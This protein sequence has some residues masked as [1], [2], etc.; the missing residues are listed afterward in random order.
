M[1]LNRPCRV[2]IRSVIFSLK[3]PKQIVH[4]FGAFF[5]PRSFF[6]KKS[7]VALAVLA[8]S[9]ASFAQSSVTVY[10][11][12][13]AWLGS[14]K[15]TSASGAETTTTT[16][17]SGGVSHDRWGFK[18]SED[19]GGGLKANFNLEQGFA[20]DTG[21]HDSG[22]TGF[23][24]YAWVGLSGGFGEIKFGKTATAY[25][26]IQ[27]AADAVFDSALSP[28]ANIFV[29]AND[30]T[31]TP[32]N[33]IM[34]VTPAMGPLGAELSYALDEKTTGVPTVTSFNVT[35]AAG[36]VA[37]SLGY[38]TEKLYGAANDTKFTRLNGSY[39]L[40]VAKLM[41]SYGK[42]SYGVATSGDV[43]EFQIGADVPVSAALTVSGSYAQSTKEA[44]TV[45]EVKK[46]G[47]GIG[48]NYTL[49]K[50]TSIYGGFETD[51][52]KDTS[53]DH[54]LFAVGVR[55]AF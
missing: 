9:G 51:K 14:V 50:R 20:L 19:L 11:V 16:L 13:D 37:A 7:L 40:G 18:G 39:D 32:S 27:G 8:A 54:S 30:Y 43:N 45:A 24:R 52:V 48:V 10:G 53:I 21:A 29:S 34:Y 47:F 25:D 35:Y 31:W 46:T 23:N 2:E 38:Q 33:S 49:S 41:A 26:D 1:R 4:W 42:V 6:M 3:A 36:P 22:S 5:K 28:A 55:H 15:N 44:T 17:G 12:L